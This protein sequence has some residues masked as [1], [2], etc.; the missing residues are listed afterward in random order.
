LK[1]DRTVRVTP[2]DLGLSIH[3]DGSFTLKFSEHRDGANLYVYVSLPDSWLTSLAEYAGRVAARR[4]ADAET[5]KAGI[6]A[7]FHAA[8]A[9]RS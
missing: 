8:A 2:M 9:G 3:G 1:N 7:T 4:T 5:L 6:E